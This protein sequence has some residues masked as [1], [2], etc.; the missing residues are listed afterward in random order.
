MIPVHLS[1]WIGTAGCLLALLF[2]TTW[3]VLSHFSRGMIRRLESKD[4]DMAVG[5]ESLLKIRDDFRV[6]VRL[7]LLLDVV[8]LAYCLASWLLHCQSRQMGFWLSASPAI[9]GALV[10]FL[11]SELLGRHLTGIAAGRLLLWTTPVLKALSLTVLPLA[12]PVILLHHWITSWQDQHA[13]EEEKTTAEDEIM[14]LLDQEEKEAEADLEEDERRM[15]RGIFDLD[16]TLVREI[17]TPRVDVDSVEDTT[18]LDEIKARIISSG[19]SRIPVYRGSID[20]IVGVVYAKDLLDDKLLSGLGGLSEIY[21]RPV[22]IPETKNVGDLLA[23]FQQTQIHFA[24]VLDEY[25][26]TAGIITFEDILEEIV[27]EIRDEYDLNEVQPT[28]E[29][30]EDGSLV[31]DAR[32]SVEEL[33]DMLNME[34]TEDQDYDTVGGYISAEAGRIPRQ[35]ENLETD[36][37]RIQ[38]LHADPRRVLKVKVARKSSDPDRKEQD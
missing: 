5:L 20:H 33:A 16:E 26:G 18:S 21:H 10:F 19:H 6:V 17:M 12:L 34:L 22:F 13:E 15:I 31:L 37:L 35:G 4:R 29:R 25:G 28:A 3:M 11:C 36:Q 23:E 38:I 7:L 27:G 1:L 24:V 32:I 14:S 9:G 30:L 8:L 2:S